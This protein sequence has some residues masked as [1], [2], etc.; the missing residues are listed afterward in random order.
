MRCNTCIPLVSESLVHTDHQST[1]T[2][3]WSPKISRIDAFDND[4]I[5]GMTTLL[6]VLS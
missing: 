2:P 6:Y 3:L 5:V 1:M 4:A